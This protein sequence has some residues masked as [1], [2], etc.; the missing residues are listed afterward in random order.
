M[1]WKRSAAVAA[2][3]LLS[4]NPVLAQR[5]PD[6]HKGFWFN[7]GGGAGWLEGASG[8]AFYVRMGGTPNRKA[9]FGGEVVT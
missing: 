7:V 9:L 6:T 4:A 1:H 3:I 8:G 2:L 5:R